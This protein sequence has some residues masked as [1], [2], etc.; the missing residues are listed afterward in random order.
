MAF[1]DPNESNADNTICGIV[2][3]NSNLSSDINVSQWWEK[4]GKPITLKKNK[5]FK[6]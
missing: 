5:C 3:K 2:L 1:H 4:Y 6:K